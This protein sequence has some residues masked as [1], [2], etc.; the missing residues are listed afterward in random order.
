MGQDPNT[1]SVNSF[2]F[3][4]PHKSLTSEPVDSSGQPTPTYVPLQG[5]SGQST[6]EQT[7]VKEI[8]N[9]LKAKSSQLNTLLDQLSKIV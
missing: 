9:Q 8:Y 3:A 6:M 1:F 4:Q 2:G 5:M 7:Q